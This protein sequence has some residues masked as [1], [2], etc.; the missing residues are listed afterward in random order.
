MIVA[1]QIR[2]YKA[3]SYHIE[4]IIQKGVGGKVNVRERV[5]DLGYGSS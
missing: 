1:T 5:R 2:G 4:K 3:Q